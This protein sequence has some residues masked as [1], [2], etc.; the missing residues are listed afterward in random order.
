MLT[1]GPWWRFLFQA[2]YVVGWDPAGTYV[3]CG[4]VCILMPETS[5][6]HRGTLEQ[7]GRVV[8][9][10]ERTFWETLDDPVCSFSFQEE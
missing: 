9:V 6:D 2:R 3:Y 10:I 5:T 8:T 1:S 4:G 7:P